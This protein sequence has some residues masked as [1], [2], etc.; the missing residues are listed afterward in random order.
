MMKAAKGFE[1]RRV[2]P[3]AIGVWDR[4]VE[5]AAHRGLVATG[6]PARQ[7]AATDKIRKGLRR[8]VAALRRRI[9]GMDQRTKFG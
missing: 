9:G 1:V 2:R 4:V 3:T 8:R 6:E 5:I 7:V